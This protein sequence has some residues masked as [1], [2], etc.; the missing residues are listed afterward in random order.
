V[1]NTRTVLVTAS[2]RLPPLPGRIGSYEARWFDRWEDLMRV[3]DTAGPAVTVLADPYFCGDAEAG[4]NVRMRELIEHRP[5]IPVVAAV[6]LTAASAP[7]V[8]TLFSW[9][10]SQ[11][12]D[13]QLDRSPA[14][15]EARLRDARARPLK[16]RIEAVL[17]RYVSENARNLIRAAC[18]VTVE[19][20][21]VLEL[22]NLFA[23]HFRT[24]ENWCPREGVPVPRRLLAWIR[25]HLAAM[26]LEEHGRSVLNVAR[27]AGYA[28]DHALRRAMRE[29]LD[30]DPSDTLRAELF[31]IAAENFNSELRE[32]RERAPHLETRA[33][34]RSRYALRGGTRGDRHR[35]WRNDG[36]GLELPLPERT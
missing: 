12:L 20:G 13:L 34:R 18:E 3:T 30:A 29:F 23:V 33:R 4:P 2:P 14:S 9:G 36:T 28:T 24:V 25:V 10:A 5:S 35:T 11:L 19:E 32:R 21:G 16:R 6:E 27:C 26:L 1:I 17:S 15:V 8:N 7:A 31:R 22:A